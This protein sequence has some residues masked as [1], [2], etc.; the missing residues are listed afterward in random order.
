MTSAAEHRAFVEQF[1]TSSVALA[2]SS[3]MRLRGV[4]ARELAVYLGID[5]DAAAKV[6]SGDW[7]PTVKM[8]ARA[9]DALGCELT[10]SIVPKAGT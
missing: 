1:A 2:L 9:V 10:I 6:V 3:A 4:T 8:L 5:E 7:N